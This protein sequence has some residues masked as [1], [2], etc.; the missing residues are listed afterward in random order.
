MSM[1]YGLIG[2]KLGHSFSPEIH[3]EIGGYDYRL[4]ELKPEEVPG[5]LREG[6][7]RGINV[8][9]PYKQ[10][11]MP[12]LD[13][14]SETARR[15]GSVNT[16]VRGGDGRLRGYN[17]DYAG[18]LGMLRRAGMNPAGKKC[19]VLGSGGASRTAVTCLRDLGASGVIV[20]SR[21][22]PDNYQNLDRHRDARLLVNATPVGMYPRNGAAPLDPAALPELEG[23]ADMIYNPARTALLLAAERRGIRTINGLYMLTGQAREACELFLG[24]RIP[25]AGTERVTGILARK[26]GNI[27][28]IGMP[29]S[30]KTTVGRILADRTGRR[31]V[32]ADEM[33]EQKAGMTCGELIRQR[34]EAAFRAL[35]TEA[36]REAGKLTGIILATGG[37]TVT[38]PENR[39]LLRQNGLLF[40]LDRGMDARTLE[41]GRPLSDSREKWERLYSARKP[42]YEAWRDV[43]IENRQP[44]EAAAGI[45]TA[46]ERGAP[47]LA[48]L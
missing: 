42:L 13:E 19:L 48:G 41:P 45:L 27:V 1:E 22:G 36:L 6:A 46:W 31:L 37:G 7:F 8:T 14:I 4:K 9:I 47:G 2:E 3:R 29:G 11:V 25:E 26:T 21:N 38:R 15:I 34:G 39:D 10:T 35:E 30:G 24:R 43:L 44:E 5:F 20:I 17:T 16:I 32:D 18:F 33:I 23:I 40:H 28:L 12:Y